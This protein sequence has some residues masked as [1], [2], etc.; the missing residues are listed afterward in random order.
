MQ[1]EELI[2]VSA[3]IVPK[4]IEERLIFSAGNEKQTLIG[5][6]DVVVLPGRRLSVA[7]GD[8]INSHTRTY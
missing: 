7:F 4:E 5:T 2:D 6:T 1:T 3:K 8:S